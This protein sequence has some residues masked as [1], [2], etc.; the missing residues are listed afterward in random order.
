MNASS[1][2]HGTFR[3]N[4]LYSRLFTHALPIPS[5]DPMITAATRTIYGQLPANGTGCHGGTSCKHKDHKCE[6][7]HRDAKLAAKFTTEQ[8]NI[9][10]KCFHERLLIKL[11]LYT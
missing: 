8:N 4:T 2:S 9:A 7:E 5:N 11:G 10:G 1:T 6:D 3:S